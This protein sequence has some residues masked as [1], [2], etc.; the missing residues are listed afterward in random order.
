[1]RSLFKRPSI[2]LITIHRVYVIFFSPF[3]YSSFSLLFL[4]VK[5]FSPNSDGERCRDGIALRKID[6]IITFW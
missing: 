3:T 1:M 6:L 4:Y 2:K 5:S